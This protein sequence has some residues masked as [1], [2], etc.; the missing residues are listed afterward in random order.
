MFFGCWKRGKQTIQ[1][2]TEKIL[3][4]SG[5]PTVQA[6]P[7]PFSWIVGAVQHLPPEWS[8][9]AGQHV[10]ETGLGRVPSCNVQ[11]VGEMG[12]VLRILARNFV[13]AIRRVQ[14]CPGS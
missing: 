4:L 6:A 7:V 5:S 2:C 10:E 11:S 3:P 8:E 14:G 12:S 9:H 13:K 1:H